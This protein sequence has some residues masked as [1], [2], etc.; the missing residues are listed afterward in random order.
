MPLSSLTPSLIKA[1]GEFVEPL[2]SFPGKALDVA[3]GVGR[4]AIW[5]A[6]RDWNVTLMDVSETGLEAARKNAEM[7]RLRDIEFE[8]RDLKKSPPEP[9]SY[10]LVLVFFYLERELF[11]ALQSALRPGGMLIYKTYTV[12][13]CKFAAG[14]THPMHLLKPNELL[15][16]FAQLRVLHYR[17][18]VRER[19]VAEFAGVKI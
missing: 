5:L 19:G 14:P 12:E 8:V 16:A 1:Y 15:H 7:K 9:D 13:Q 3:G 17:E 11:P 6:E 2:F 4:H 10:D 18:T